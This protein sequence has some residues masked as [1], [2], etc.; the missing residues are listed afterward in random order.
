MECDVETGFFWILQDSSRLPR[1]MSPEVVGAG[2][3][4][5]RRG[6]GVLP[7]PRSA[8][9]PSRAANF[10]HISYTFD[11]QDVNDYNK[12]EEY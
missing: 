2:L 5:A 8:A 6:D 9:T 1:R 3:V 12:E 7:R 11:S 4:P 10:I